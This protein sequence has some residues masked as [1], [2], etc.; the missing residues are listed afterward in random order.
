[1]RGKP[2]QP[3]ATLAGAASLSGTY[4]PDTGSLL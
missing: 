3:G 2:D 4:T 1:M